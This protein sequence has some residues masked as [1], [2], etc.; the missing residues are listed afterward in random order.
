MLVRARYPAHEGRYE[1]DAH[2]RLALSL[3]DAER[4]TYRCGDTRIDGPWRA[5]QIVVTPPGAPLESQCEAVTTL[6]L[7]IDPAMVGGGRSLD[8]TEGLGLVEDELLSSVMRALWCEADVHGASTAFFQHGA[9]LVVRRL[10]ELQGSSI[11]TIAQSRLP[12]A[13]LNLVLD[14]I[15][16]HLDGD[17]TVGDM[18]ARAGRE[19]SGFARAFKTDMGCTPYT[20]LTRR[21]M[22]RAQALL[23]AGESVARTACAC[24]Y[25]NPAQFSL[26]F[27]RLLGASPTVWRARS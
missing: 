15:E 1:G 18:A 10:G 4:L 14:W 16:N 21:R 2:L 9:A 23:R 3:G 5:G 8:A 6:G 24:G 26:A 7:A 27:R 13:R 20:Y 17:I 11:A 19:V 22:A 25:A 12:R